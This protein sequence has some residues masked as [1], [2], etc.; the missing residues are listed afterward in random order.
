MTGGRGLHGASFIAKGHG[1][2]VCESGL[3]VDHEDTY[4]FTVGT[5][6]VR[7]T[8]VGD[9]HRHHHRA[10]G[11][12]LPGCSLWTGCELMGTPLTASAQR[13]PRPIPV[14]SSTIG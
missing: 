4:R 12:D 13:S 8:R 3:V 5:A 9:H 2:Q 14:A 7:G 11:F 10:G 1:E 6:K